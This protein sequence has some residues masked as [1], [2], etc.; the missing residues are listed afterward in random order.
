[1]LAHTTPSITA[2]EYLLPRFTQRY[3]IPVE[4][5]SCS[6]LS[7]VLERV[8]SPDENWDVVRLDPSNLTYL[9]PRLLR[10][11]DEVDPS[12]SSALHQFFPNLQNDFSV[13]GGKLFALP[14]DISVQMLFYQRSLFEDIGQM[15]AYYEETGETLEVPG[16]FQQLDRI[17]RFFTKAHR[18][19]SP[20]RFGA[21]LAPS[22]P[23]SIS[24]DYLPRLLAAGGFPTAATAA[25]T[26]P[27]PP[28]FPVCG[29]TSPMPPAPAWNQCRVGAKLPQTLW[30]VKPP[31]PSCTSTTPPVLCGPKAPMWG[32]KL[33]TPPFREGTLCWRAVP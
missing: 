17:C 21:S 28:L 12:A 25:W 31:P 7:E 8:A 13:V 10:H 24:N 20:I 6:S 19:D 30:T 2:L 22:N 32:W 23:T 16:T 1:V 5:Y 9:G 4:L 33:A 11:L 27:R 26:S 29:T 14:F 3:G 15:R 18:P